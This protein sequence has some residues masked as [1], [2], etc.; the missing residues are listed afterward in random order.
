MTAERTSLVDDENAEDPGCDRDPGEDAEHCPVDRMST[1]APAPEDRQDRAGHRSVGGGQQQ[2]RH[3]VEEDRLGCLAHGTFTIW[4]AKWYADDWARACLVKM[5]LPAY[6]IRQASQLA[7]SSLGDANRGGSFLAVCRGE[8][9]RKGPLRRP[10]EQRAFSY[11]RPVPW[12]RGQEGPPRL[13][14]RLLRRRRARRRD[15]GEG[16]RPVRAARLRAQAD[17]PQPAR[18]PRPRGARCGVRGRG[19]RGAGG[20]DR[21]LLGPRRRAVRARERA[22]AAAEHDRRHLPA[23]HQG[24]R[25]GTTLRRRRLHRRADR[26][27]GPRGSRRD[28]GRGARLDGAR[29]IGRGCR[30]PPV[31]TGRATRLRHA[32]DALRRRDRRDH[33]RAAPALP[34]HLRAQE[35]RHLLRHVQPPVGGQGDAARDRAAARDRLAQ[36]V[37][38]EPAGRDRARGGGR[39][40]PDR[41]RVG[42]RRELARRRRGRGR[43]LGSLGAREARRTRL[44][45]VPRPRRRRRSSRSGSS[46]RASSSDCRPSCAASS[47]SPRPRA[48]PGCCE[49]GTRFAQEVDGGGLE[50][51]STGH[52]SAL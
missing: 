24:A 14:T 34:E 3:A 19:D 27:R 29:R 11:S 42:D 4:A 16:A 23:R 13:P 52:L 49:A 20:R 26:P 45:L 47:P 30:T 33:H 46:T 10:P 38:L 50:P 51:A 15:R 1:A 32:D 44:R 2:Q 35:G 12:P 22:G 37:E 36:L 48:E 7:S 6:S 39:R 18:R 41:R 17:R 8:R 28:D 9:S 21:R 40:P 31:R 5:G 25:A 43:H